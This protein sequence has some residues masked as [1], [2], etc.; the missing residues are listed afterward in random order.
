MGLSFHYSGRIADKK[1]L[2]K[3]IED[4]VDIAKL[5]KW[6]YHVLN[7][8]FPDEQEQTEAHNHKV[9]GIFFTPPE[10][11]TVFVSFLSNGRL[12]SPLLLEFWGD[13]TEEPEIGY[14]YMLSVKTQY[15][16]AE[17]HKLLMGIFHYLNKQYFA[18]FEMSDEGNYWATS[19]DTLLLKNFNQNGIL[20]NSFKSVLKNLPIQEDENPEEYIIR[21]I[22][23]IKHNQQPKQSDDENAEED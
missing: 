19:N 11:E 5:H 8:E 12:S 17:I 20:I 9:Y 13:A 2:P 21:I 6:K 18:E 14:L 1:F 10:C 22:K 15:A 16:G 7:C 4:L 23:E 3:L